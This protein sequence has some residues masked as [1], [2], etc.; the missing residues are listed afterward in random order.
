MTKQNERPIAVIGAGSWGTALAILL[1][2]NGS[3]VRL[4][5]HIR[6]DMLLMQKKRLNARYLP[7]IAFPENLT[8]EIEL[9]DAIQGV[10]DLLIVVPS[11]AFRS[12]LARLVP[13][14]DDDMRVVWGTKGL[15]SETCETLD[16]VAK[17][18]LGEQ[19]PLAIISGPS[20]ASEVAEGLPTALTLACMD[21]EFSQSLI[22][23]FSNDTFR[24]YRSTDL[25]G[26]ELCGVMKNVL[27]IAAGICD[28]L[29]L[30]A[31]ARSALLT[32]GVAELSRL[33]QVTGGD[34]QTLMSLAGFGDIVLTCTT[35]Q[36]RNRRFGLMIGA[37]ISINEA[38]RKIGQ[39]V[40]GYVNTTQLF[41]LA[42]KHNLDMPIVNA[43][44]RIFQENLSPKDAATELLSRRA[45]G[46]WG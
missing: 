27:A 7:G 28:G 40:E 19:I 36:S 31:N 26:V 22:D 43:V 9:V 25:I 44:Y 20:F 3:V 8:P 15:D 30:G 38:A 29:K 24:L 16:V 11:A 21:G 33:L 13:L 17:Q 37:G 46:A 42:Q 14:I 35:D 23:R 39:V 10:R 6:D 4:W 1:A 18:I 2:R 32:R 41:R 45:S 12:V 34:L 5:G